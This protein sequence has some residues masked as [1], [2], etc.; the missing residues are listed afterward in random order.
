M[1]TGELRKIH[2][3]VSWMLSPVDKSIT[4]SA[5]Q[6]IDHTSLSTSSSMLDVTAEL[7][8]L[9]FTLMR[10]LRP[11]IIGS[12]SG[13]LM[14]LGITARPRAT[15]SRTNSAVISVG[16]DALNEWP[17]FGSR[18]VA[19]RSASCARTRFSRTAMYSISGVMMPRRA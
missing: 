6:R 10:K 4:V 5:P 7:P 18:S 19:K 12:L 11:I 14:L 9:A 17:F 1:G 3:R 2:S 13:W 8:M 16:M 15:S